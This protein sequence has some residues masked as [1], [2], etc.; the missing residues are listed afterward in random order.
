M[1]SS[2]FLP[3]GSKTDGAKTGVLCPGM[4][5]GGWPPA[6]LGAPTERG[7]SGTGTTSLSEFN[8]V[9]IK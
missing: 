7:S 1:F 6:S 3:T 8:T 2:P 4:H 9:L 5:E